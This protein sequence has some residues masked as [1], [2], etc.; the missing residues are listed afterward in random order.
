M[1][2]G[3]IY[4]DVNRKVSREKLAGMA[5]NDVQASGL[6]IDRNMGFACRAYYPGECVF[7]GIDAGLFVV[8]QGA[9]YNTADLLQTLG[10][11]NRAN[12]SA[13]VIGHLYREHGEA[14]IQRLRGKF[15]FAL[16]DRKNHIV[17]LGRDRLGIESLCYFED[18]EKILFGT[19]LS[20]IA[21]YPGF[22][23]RLN[24]GAVQQ[25]L[26]SCYN[27]TTDTFYHGIQKLRTGY[28]LIHRNG[29]STIKR[30]WKLSFAVQSEADESKITEML[31][32]A[33]RESVRIRTDTTRACGVFVSG[34]L[35]SSTV[36]AL[37][38]EASE[39]PL[40][41]FSYRCRGE[42][43]DESPYAQMVSRY[44]HT[45]HSLIEYPADEVLSIQKMVDVMDEPFC[46]VGINIA[47]DI[48]GRTARR[49]AAYVMTGDGG[50]ELFGGHPIYLADGVGRLMDR[51]PGLIK[52]PLFWMGLRLKDSDKKKDF[53]VKWKRFSQS[54]A[55]P[56]S[57]LSHRW[58]MY[59]TPDELADLIDADRAEAFDLSHPFADLL[60]FNSEAD[61]EE[62][63]DRSLYSDYQ[64]VVGF[65]LRRMDLIRR[66]S[67]ESRFP[68][69]DHRLVEFCATIPSDLKIR[70]GSDAKYILKQTIKDILP[71]EIVFRKDKLGHSIPLKNWMRD[72]DR[73]KAMMM[74]LLSEDSL[75]K[76]G[77]FRAAAVSRFIDEHL[78]KR[79]N[80]SHRLWALMV[81]EL[82]FRAHWD[83]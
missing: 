9:L 82:W 6:N 56:Q 25:F 60:E 54:M 23:K 43:F 71:H 7:D 42:S 39:E 19:S 46:D 58:R 40:H 63:L 80:H 28:L 5:S 36:L 51:M 49:K 48:L 70:K 52:N 37:T 15:A 17:M 65:Y 57:L 8:F 77:L 53:W 2:W 14:C 13:R 62:F 32:D 69:L 78:A 59:Y 1:I 55:F 35:D 3:V 26:Q 68:M 11:Q 22:E 45:I 67:I 30:Y 66:Y 72:N 18:E 79:W 75:K 83:G 74:D 73:V 31:L 64:T 21:G 81:L 41:T 38:R 27:P 10:G 50:D 33:M 47:T 24:H 61:G 12:T 34:G 29:S 76:R 44:Y 20:P 16:Y 4:K